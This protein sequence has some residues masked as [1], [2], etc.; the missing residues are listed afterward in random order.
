ML[1]ERRQLQIAWNGQT[2]SLSQVAPD[3]TLALT[4]F[5]RSLS[6]RT[7]YMRYFVPLQL[8]AAERIDM[9]IARL[10]DSQS[11]LTLAGRLAGRAEIIAVVEIA[12]LGGNPQAAEIALTVDDVYQRQGIGRGIFARI[13]ELLAGRCVEQI[14]ATA[15]AENIAV[16]KLFSTLG[17]YSM[18]RSGDTVAFQ[19]GM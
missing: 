13:P 5:L 18:Q 2:L 17:A 15:L 19:A 14:H 3:D 1:T 12:F 8:M 7:L 10:L 4:A 6:A 16:R 11:R 9:E